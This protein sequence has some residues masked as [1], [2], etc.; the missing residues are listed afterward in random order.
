MESDAN[1]NID[2][3]IFEEE[4]DDADLFI[5][6]L[7]KSR[8]GVQWEELPKALLCKRKFRN[9]IR[10]KVAPKVKVKTKVS[11]CEMYL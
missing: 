1:N 9:I 7:Y 3:S 6:S 11:K 2:D 5:D 4:N 8:S 10:H